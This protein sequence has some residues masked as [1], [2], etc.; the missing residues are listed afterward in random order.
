MSNQR[1]TR[2]DVLLLV[3]A[4][5]LAGFNL[6]LGLTGRLDFVHTVEAPTR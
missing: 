2:L 4:L 3:I 1:W 6:W 5:T